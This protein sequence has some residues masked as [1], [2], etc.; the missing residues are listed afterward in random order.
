MPEI[1]VLVVDDEAPVRELL[2]RWLEGWGYRV[3]QAGNATDA[4]ESMLAK[5][6]PI[7]FCDVTMPGHDGL[8][9]IERVR[10]KWQ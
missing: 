6:A 8:W 10:A 1:S 3:T 5:P 7:L 4:L 9:L 2:R